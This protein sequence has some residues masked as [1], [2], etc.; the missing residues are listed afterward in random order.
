MKVNAKKV[1]LAETFLRVRKC[2]TTYAK[3][4]LRECRITQGADG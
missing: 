4:I 3:T 1:D 2:G